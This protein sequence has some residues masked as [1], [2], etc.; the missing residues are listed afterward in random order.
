MGASVRLRGCGGRGC[1]A[2]PLLPATALGCVSWTHKS[3]SLGSGAL[4]S[5][6]GQGAI[7]ANSVGPMG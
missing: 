6:C 2:G 3:P 5:P 1:G 7:L 4:L